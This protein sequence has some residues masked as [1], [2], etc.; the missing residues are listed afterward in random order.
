ME[1]SVTRQ[2]NDQA[3]YADAKNSTAKSIT[4]RLDDATDADIKFRSCKWDGHAIPGQLEGTLTHILKAFA[5]EIST[6]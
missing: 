4:I 2:Y 5:E 1:V 3:Q 6:S